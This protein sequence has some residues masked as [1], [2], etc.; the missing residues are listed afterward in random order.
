M[1][2][3]EIIN[4][5]TSAEMPDIEEVRAMC[6]KAA[7]QATRKYQLP[8]FAAALITVLLFAIT[9]GA[10]YAALDINILPERFHATPHRFEL[11]GHSHL[12]E[13]PTPQDGIYVVWEWREYQ[14]ALRDY[15]WARLNAELTAVGPVPYELFCCANGETNMYTHHLRNRYSRWQWS[16]EGWAW[17][18]RGY[19]SAEGVEYAELQRVGTLSIKCSYCDMVDTA[20][21]SF[22]FLEFAW[23]P[24]ASLN[25]RYITVEQLQLVDERY[26]APVGGE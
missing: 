21:Y 6:H 8:K 18:S 23:V 12:D 9:G 3:K 24:I 10:L 4:H 26:P 5:I 17:D 25:S 1:K 14:K 20:R 15:A 22:T 7:T 11:I 2:G 13:E 19:V 16:R